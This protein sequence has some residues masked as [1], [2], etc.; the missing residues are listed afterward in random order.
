MLRWFSNHRKRDR[1]IDEYFYNKHEYFEWRYRVV[2]GFPKRE[3]WLDFYKREMDRL[4]NKITTYLCPHQNVQYRDDEVVYI[5]KPDDPIEDRILY[6]K[7]D[8]WGKES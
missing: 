6:G 1:L 2:E 7:Q 4:Y 8:K 5:G 3:Y